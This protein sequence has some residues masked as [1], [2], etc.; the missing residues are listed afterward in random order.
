MM[1][2]GGYP[3]IERGCT[4]VIV[5]LGVSLPVAAM[6][7]HPDPAAILRGMFIPTM[8]NNQGLYSAMLLLA[9]MIGAQAGSLSNLSY[10]LLR[11]REG[12][13]RSRRPAAS[14]DRSA[15]EHDVPVWRRHPVAGRRGGDL[16]AA[17]HPAGER[18]ASGAHLQREH[19][20]RGPGDLRRR[21][22]GHLFQQLCR[23]HDGL[24]AD[25]ARHLPALRARAESRR[26]SRRS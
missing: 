12:M 8:P 6:L 11:H 21:A 23:R 17:R 16:V 25:R 24:L 7:S 20:A 18:R 14:A 5:I 15:D 4:V 19:G 2:S 3:L 9:A 13:V 1:I 26:R 22:V 10:T